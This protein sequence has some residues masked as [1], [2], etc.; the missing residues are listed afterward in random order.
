VITYYFPLSQ[1]EPK[2]AR[3]ALYAASTEEWSKSIVKDLEKMH[4]GIGN[5]IISIDLWPWGHGM[6][7]P[8]VGEIWGESRQSMKEPRGNI[9]F[10]HSDMSGI[11]NF[12]EAQYHGVE[13]AKMILARRT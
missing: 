13:A 2:L 4:P 8:S 5:E 12:E 10:A 3:K 7:R 9:L 6:V 11:S 1:Q